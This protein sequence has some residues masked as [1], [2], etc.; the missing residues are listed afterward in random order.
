MIYRVMSKSRV[1][2]YSDDVN[3]LEV[4]MMNSFDDLLSQLLSERLHYEVLRSSAGP[5]DQLVASRQRLTAL[6]ASIAKVRNV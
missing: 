3:G 2:H 4:E 6:R 5:L 1:S